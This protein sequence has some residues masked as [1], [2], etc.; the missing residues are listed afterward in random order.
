M[1][2]FTRKKADLIE[3]PKPTPQELLSI[4]EALATGGLHHAIENS[5]QK[6]IDASQYYQAYEAMDDQGNYFGSEFNIR[7]TAGRIK[8]TYTREPWI[9]A[10][11]SLI[12]KSM[13]MVPF[14]LLN[15]QTN[16]YETEHAL[17]K[18]VELGN[19]LE[20]GYTLKWKGYLDLVLCGNFFRAYN[21]A[22]TESA[23]LPAEL[24]C[25]ELDN[26][27]RFIESVQVYDNAKPGVRTSIPYKQV[28]HFKYP[29]PFNVYYGL[30]LFVAASRPLLLD[31]YKNE[32]EM[33][34]YLRGATNSGVIET[35]D[36]IN[37]TR[38]ERLMRT[39]EAV[40]TGKRNWWR[41]IFLP[42]G[43]SWK[44]SGLSM[45]EMQ[46]LEGL[47][48]NRLTIL[49][50]LG[51]PPSKVGIVQDVNRSTSEDQDKTFWT[52]TVQPLC[53][54]VASGWNNSH[55]FKV[56]YGG[57]YKLEPDYSGI[58]AL[59]GSL[60]TKGEQA[61]AV[62][63]Y[64]L[65]DEIREDILGY[66][67]LPDGRGQFFV[68]EIKPAGVPGGDPFANLAHHV[69]AVPDPVQ[70]IATATDALLTEIPV[71]KAQAVQS[72]ERIENKLTNE[73]IKAYGK[74]IDELL[75]A[76]S[77]ALAN[78]RDVEKFLKS[79]EKDLARVYVK[80]AE[81]TL[82]KALDRGVSFAMAQSKAIWVA[83]RALGKIAEKK[84]KFNETD[85]QALDALRD[86]T[87]DGQRRTLV[88][89]SITSFVGFNETRTNEVLNLIAEGVESGKT[90][91]QIAAEIRQTYGERYKDQAFTIA[92]TELLTAVSQ[93]IKWNHDLLQEVFSD[94]K[95]QWIHV[96]DVGSNPDAR[97]WH[98]GYESLG[99]VDKDYV[100]DGE[101]EYPRDPNGSASDNVNCRCSMVSVVPDDATSNAEAILDRL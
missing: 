4:T 30:S 100:Y 40:Y 76:A 98:A 20:D 45:T 29:N 61:K 68:T 96:G 81:P 70:E 31:R 11:A 38:M 23:H 15:L 46:H 92:R 24:V 37:K 75:A 53:E 34:F 54:F 86:E 18:K 36:D 33:A 41:T 82:I 10:S 67:K 72:Q 56:I 90:T 101:L 65:I 32:F 9:F 44:S 6:Q 99:P 21:A 51:I 42:K 2:L 25:L 47:R 27:K 58:E 1:G 55:L 59:Q 28:V 5:I 78:N 84:L 91:D 43:A 77:Y 17:L 3:I 63:G 7:A 85:Q 74:Y 87:E 16:Q 69:D 26:Q 79:K 60:R 13:A 19:P 57:K 14:K 66:D 22:F 88:S 83:N 35:T 64:L 89:R 12:A 50:V 97:E 62:E 95:K 8:G 52:N 71:I 80:E 39:F 48:E 49:A 93:G 94:V 73:Y